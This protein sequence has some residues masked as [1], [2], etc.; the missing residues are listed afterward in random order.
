MI[1]FKRMFLSLTSKRIEHTTMNASTRGKTNLGELRG[2]GQLTRLITRD[3]V[4]LIPGKERKVLTTSDIDPA[5]G[6]LYKNFEERRRKLREASKESSCV[7]TYD[8][9]KPDE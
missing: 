6:K 4:E 5:T 2:L 8:N 1:D 7:G 3:P 9:W